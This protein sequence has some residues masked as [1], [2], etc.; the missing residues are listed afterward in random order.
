MHLLLAAAVF[1]LQGDPSKI[2]WTTPGH[3]KKAFERC[4]QEGRLLV[5]KGI[6]FGVDAEG[7]VCATKGD[8]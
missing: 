5:L 8:W 7:A 4:G 2:E 6:S 1:C 3:F